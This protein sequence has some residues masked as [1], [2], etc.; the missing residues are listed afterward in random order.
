MKVLIWIGCFVVATILNTILGAVTGIKA[1]YLVFYLVVFFVARALCKKWDEYKK[2]KEDLKKYSQQKFVSDEIKTETANT[3][4]AR[5]YRVTEC[6]SCGYR[7]N[8]FFVE[9]PNCGKNE[10]RFVCLNQEENPENDKIS[11][12]RNCGEKLIDSSQFCRKCG[13][14]VLDE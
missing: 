1:G 2:E 9:C 5:F 4:N 14:K 7:D 13:T 10:K 3:N 8:D 11:F 6:R 12:C